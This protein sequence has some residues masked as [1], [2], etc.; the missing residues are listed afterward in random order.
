MLHCWDMGSEL[1][2]LCFA[3]TTLQSPWF[4]IVNVHQTAEQHTTLLPWAPSCSNA[5]LQWYHGM[6]IL[7][8][9]ACMH[10][11]FQ[12]LSTED[13]ISSRKCISASLTQ[14]I[15]VLFSRDNM[16][17]AVTKARPEAE[18]GTGLEG[19]SGSCELWVSC[20]QLATCGQ[21][22]LLLFFFFPYYYYLFFFSQTD[23]T[24]LT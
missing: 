10:I 21:K 14:N 22:S 4:L 2:R 18:N 15:T 16:W 6:H 1:L 13:W 19:P 9:H 7:H 5:S 12:I 17:N 8:T 23:C 24:L 20:G 11:G 3:Y